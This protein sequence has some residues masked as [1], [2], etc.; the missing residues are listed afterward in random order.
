M[1]YK[2]IIFLFMVSAF[3]FGHLLKSQT[4]GEQ[5]NKNMLNAIEINDVAAADSLSDIEISRDLAE[6]DFDMERI[7][8]NKSIDEMN[9]LILE[10]FYKKHIGQNELKYDEQRPIDYMFDENLY[11]RLG[12][13]KDNQELFDGM[14]I[15]ERI[16]F[17]LLIVLGLQEITEQDVSLIQMRLAEITKAIEVN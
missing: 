2:L 12:K 8:I 16:N 3:S 6:R 5:I 1:Q 17:C 11:K 4:L 10:I 14:S 9:P 15:G 7:W 13:A